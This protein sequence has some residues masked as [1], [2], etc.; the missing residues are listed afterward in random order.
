MAAGIA[1]HVWKM[2]EIVALMVAHEAQETTT[3]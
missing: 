3:A 1:D 2:E